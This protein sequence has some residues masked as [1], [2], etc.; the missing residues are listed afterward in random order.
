M[1]R[2]AGAW[3]S[4]FALLLCAGLSHV[5]VPSYCV[6]FPPETPPFGECNVAVH[7]GRGLLVNNEVTQHTRSGPTR[8]ILACV[9]AS[10]NFLAAALLFFPCCLITYLPN[11]SESAPYILARFLLMEKNPTSR[12][13]FTRVSGCCS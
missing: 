8:N 4:Y 9:V 6:L 5:P 11:G 1:Y 12:I 2:P 7:T 13:A 3:Y 10:I